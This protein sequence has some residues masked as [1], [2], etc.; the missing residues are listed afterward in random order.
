MDTKKLGNAG[1]DLAVRFLE[2]AGHE[3]LDR[4]YRIRNGEIDIISREKQEKDR[5]GITEYLVF[6]E[7]KT[8]SGK[9]AGDPYEAVGREKQRKILKAAERYL[10][11]K[12]L[13]V[14]TPVRFDVISIVKEEITWYKNAYGL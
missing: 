6:T 4:N 9:N 1:E 13:P 11:E 2:E 10:Y 14:D 5:F 7:V 3:I 8:R 12:K